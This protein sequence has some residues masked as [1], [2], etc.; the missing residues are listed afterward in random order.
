MKKADLYIRARCDNPAAHRTFVAQQE[1]VLSEYCATHQLEIG[2][3]IL[4]YCS[5]GNFERSGWTPYY[6]HLQ[7]SPVKPDF[8]L[9]TSWDRFSRNFEEL[10]T[11]KANL[12]RM[13]IT[14]MPI[15]N[16]VSFADALKIYGPQNDSFAR[17][18]IANQFF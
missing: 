15:D 1:K 17:I 7:S 2:K 6:K 9:F 12:N 16:Q 3:K 13:G 8:I 5:A 18:V 4:D 14:I 11:V 10:V